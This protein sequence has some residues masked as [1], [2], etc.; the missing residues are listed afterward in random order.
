VSLSCICV[1]FVRSQE[2]DRQ[3]LYVVGATN[4]VSEWP[5]ICVLGVSSQESERPCICLLGVASQE[6]GRV[7]YMCAICKKPGK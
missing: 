3:F 7:M 2:S 1:L 4:H 5:C 6:F